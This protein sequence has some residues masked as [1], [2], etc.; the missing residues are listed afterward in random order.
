MRRLIMVVLT[1]VIGL[2]LSPALAQDGKT[3]K[4]DPA[5][6]IQQASQL[7][8]TGDAKKDMAL[9]TD[10]SKAISAANVVCNGYT[11]TGKGS[12]VLDPF[13]LPKGTYRMKLD[14]PSQDAMLAQLDSVGDDFCIGVT[15][16]KKREERVT[17]SN[18]CRAV[19]QINTL[20]QDEATWTVTLE[21]LK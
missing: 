4:C 18:G 2:S 7:K 11:F 16:D 15:N 12:K 10:L 5:A 20:G 19:I 21:P 14:W 13:D 1:I 9:L 3:A 6:V 17:A 8:S